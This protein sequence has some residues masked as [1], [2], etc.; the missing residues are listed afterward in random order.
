MIVEGIARYVG[1]GPR[2]V[3]PVYVEI[4]KDFRYLDELIED[5]QNT[6]PAPQY[7][8]E[9]LY[10]AAPISLSHVNYTR[11]YSARLTPHSVPLSEAQHI[12]WTFGGS[13]MQNHETT[14]ELTIANT[15]AK[16]L[17]ERIGPTHVKNFGAGSFFSS[18]ELIKFQKLLREVPVEER[19]TMAVFYDGYNDAV[20][21][22]LFGAGSLQRDLSLK[23]Q[24]LVEH[25]YLVILSY[26]LFEIAER[27]SKFWELTGARLMEYALFPPQKPQ[28]DESNLQSA[29]RVY[30]DN[31]TMIQATCEV[32]GIECFFVLQPLIVT[33]SQLMGV[34]QEVFENLKIGPDGIR[35]VRGFYRDVK[36]RLTS[37]E[38]FIN[39]SDILDGRIQ[40]DFYDVG[41]TAAQTPP[42]IGE[43][44]AGMLLEKLAVE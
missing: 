29:V 18:Y 7:Y 33:K 11:Y 17:N 8:D 22:Y 27:V 6:H 37:N 3:N 35:F 5:N 28:A 9:F 31:V 43:K 25:K 32:F 26:A 13:T 19:P 1:R 23:L 40:P 44:I 12:V 39:A 41:H 15:W 24:A 34:E 10:A 36:E 42:F 20:H 2:W 30:T 14:D 21:S 4:S 16:V 38:H